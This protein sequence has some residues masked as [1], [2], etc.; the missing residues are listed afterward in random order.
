MSTAKSKRPSPP[1]DGETRER[2]VAGARRHFF[3][4]G[5]RSVTMDDLARELGMSKKTLYAHFGSKPELLEAAIFAKM[6]E[7]EADFAEIEARCGDQI[8]ATL[9]EYLACLQ[10]HS[11]EITPPFLRD[12]QSVATELWQRVEAGRAAIFERYFGKLFR[13]GRK[14]GLIRGD[15][16]PQLILAVMLGL[17]QQIL[18]PLKLTELNLTPQTAL[19]HTLSILLHGVF[20]P[21]KATP[22]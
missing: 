16:P 5:F 4:H 22:R 11:G 19:S 20:L 13:E 1:S 15:L 8:E 2:I 10:R 7:L 3:A 21:A 6:S 17:V 14:A 9:R 12:M 18:N